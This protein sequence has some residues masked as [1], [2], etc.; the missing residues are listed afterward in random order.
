MLTQELLDLLDEPMIERERV[1]DTKLLKLPKYKEH[2][3]DNIHYLDE[4]VSVNQFMQET[5]FDSIGHYDP[6]TYT[7][8]CYVEHKYLEDLVNKHSNLPR[9]GTDYRDGMPEV[10]FG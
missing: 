9:F 1:Y 3:V 2:V 7:I 6:E 8:V 5:N 10:M 4:T